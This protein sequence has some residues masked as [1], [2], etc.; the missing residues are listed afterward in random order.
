MADGELT[1]ALITQCFYGPDGADRLAGR[2]AEAASRGAEVAVLPELPL[3]EWVPSSQQHHPDDAEE[4]DGRRSRALTEAAR[5]AGIGVLGGVI[6]VDPESGKRF[7]TALLL[8]S[9]GQLCGCYEKLHL[10]HEAGF[11]EKSHYRPGR[12][13]PAPIDGFGLKLGVQLCSDVNR[14][15]GSL[16]LAALGAEVILNPRATEET[17]WPRWRTVLTANALTGCCYVASINRPGP[18]RGVPIGG[19]SFLV[20]PNGEVLLETTDPVAV[21]RLRREVV[22]DARSRYPGYLDLFPEIYRRGWAAVE[23][24]SGDSGPSA[25]RRC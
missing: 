14:P 15:Q 20:D 12:S 25:T 1:L 2:L 3:D 18:E 23:R 6:L 5:E 7:S 8:D 19:P 10:P 13:Q 24:G 4:A 22:E 9:A 16:L 11:W 21:A 17:T